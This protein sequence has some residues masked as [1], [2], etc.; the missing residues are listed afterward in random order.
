MSGQACR[1]EDRMTAHPLIARLIAQW[2]R[3]GSTDAR[4]DHA[5]RTALPENPS[6]MLDA[7]ILRRLLVLNLARSATPA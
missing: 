4:K 7:S 5:L 3:G 1:R 6:A 2:R